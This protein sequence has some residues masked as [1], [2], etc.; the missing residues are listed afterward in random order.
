MAE[1][2]ARSPSD[3]ELARIEADAPLFLVY[4]R[5]IL[6]VLLGAAAFFFVANLAR[7]S[8]LPHIAEAGRAA[9]ILRMFDTDGEATIP[10]FFSAIMLLGAGGLLWA[11]ARIYKRDGRPH[12]MSWRILALIFAALAVDEFASFHERVHWLLMPGFRPTGFLIEGWVVPYAVLL[13]VLVV[14]LARWFLALP[15]RTQVL[16]AA[17]AILFVGG[18]I[19]WEMVAS[20]VW[21]E[22]GRA[23]YDQAVAQPRYM[24]LASIEELWEMTGAALW[25]YTL[26]DLIARQR[27]SVVFLGAINIGMVGGGA[28]AAPAL[29]ASVARDTSR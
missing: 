20:Q 26:V 4:P 3:S 2:S 12:V 25:V 10:A 9:Y 19:G 28:D 5:R 15:R 8:V 11:C 1:P 16:G 21:A 13:V 24:Y 22:L 29:D 18:A 6:I 27:R 14:M 17:S 23:N 7:I